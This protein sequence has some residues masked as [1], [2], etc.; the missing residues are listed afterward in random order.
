MRHFLILL[1]GLL[2]VQPALA[3]DCRVGK[4]IQFTGQVSL[5]RQGQ[6]LMVKP[7]MRLCLKDR[8][9]TAAKSIAQLRLRDG[10]L[11]TVGKASKFVI[12]DFQFSEHNPGVALFELVKGA[13]RCVTGLITQGPHRVEVRTSVATI[14]IRGT[15]FWGGFGLTENALDVIMLKGKGVYVETGQGR[16]L[17]DQPGL[18]TTVV[19]GMK[20]TPP[21]TWKPAK[22][23]QALATITP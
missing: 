8:I 19:A 13:F 12:H 21:A 2:L 23:E 20:P 14:G 17:L 9:A 15:D 11:V 4:L 1:C 22:L 6:S 18:G 3:K 5:H 7:G 10:T 16:V